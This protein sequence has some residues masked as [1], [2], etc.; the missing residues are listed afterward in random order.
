[1]PVMGGRVGVVWAGRGMVR[2]TK[3]KAIVSGMVVRDGIGP[4]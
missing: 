3:K 2:T 1:M 4:T